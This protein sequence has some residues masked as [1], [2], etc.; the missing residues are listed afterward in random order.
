MELLKMIALALLL[1]AAQLAPSHTA[2]HRPAAHRVA[3]ARKPVRRVQPLLINVLASCS[4]NPSR[5][6]CNP[7]PNVQYRLTQLPGDTPYDGKTKSIEFAEK[8]DTCG[9]VGMPVCPHE[10]K[11]WVKVELENPE[12]E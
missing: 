7:D 4:V 11:P 8:H 3:R 5:V 6:G 1:V 2:Y 9:V 12:G 10:R